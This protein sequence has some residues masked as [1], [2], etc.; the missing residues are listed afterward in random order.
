MLSYI[1]SC[2]YVLCFIIVIKSSITQNISR[3]LPDLDRALRLALKAQR[4]RERSNTR[5]LE[6][7]HNE[8]KNQ[9][10]INTIVNHNKKIKTIENEF[11]LIINNFANSTHVKEVVNKMK[12]IE[13]HVFGTP[14]PHSSWREFLLVAIVVEVIGVL[15]IKVG[16]K[17][18]V[19]ELAKCIS[20]RITDKT[21]RLTTIS[22][23][24]PSNY[25]NNSKPTQ[26]QKSLLEQWIHDQ[27]E[28]L[29]E[30]I[31]VLDME[32]DKGIQPV[33]NEQR[34]TQ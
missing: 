14:R 24:I 25:H 20:K 29:N 8:N 16:N 13:K 2:A 9:G 10:L 28:K 11:N 19:P 21:P 30:L 6:H 7:L 22:G 5:D 3:E 4:N 33:R 31:Y 15:L 23:N 18:I 32:R 34:I 12:E 26:E 27:S 17:C 1:R